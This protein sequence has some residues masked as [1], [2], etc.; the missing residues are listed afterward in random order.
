MMQPS[1][2]LFLMIIVMMSFCINPTYLLFSQIGKPIL[3]SVALTLPNA[4]ARID[5]GYEI[6]KLFFKQVFVIIICVT[7]VS[8]L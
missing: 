8:S 4:S 1:K 6:W 2:N 5:H 3:D 7:G